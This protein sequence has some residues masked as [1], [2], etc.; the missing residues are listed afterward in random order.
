MGERDG[1]VSGVSAFECENNWGSLD[2]PQHLATIKAVQ[3]EGVAD[4]R[5]AIYGKSYGGFMDAGQQRRIALRN[6]RSRSFR[7]D[8]V[9]RLADLN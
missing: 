7:V 2:L 1:R 9:T 3:D 4:D 6:L 8:Y 5:L